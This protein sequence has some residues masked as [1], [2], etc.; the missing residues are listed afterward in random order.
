MIDAR[1]DKLSYI[2]NIGGREHLRS[3][4]MP[5]PESDADL[6]KVDERD[7]FEGGVSTSSFAYR[8]N[9]QRNGRKT[10]LVG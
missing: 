1:S 6:L 5:M 9:G 2:V 10:G 4:H 7:G 3:R 8:K